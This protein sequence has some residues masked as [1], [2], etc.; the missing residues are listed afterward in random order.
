MRRLS[1]SVLLFSLLTACGPDKVQDAVKQFDLTIIGKGSGTVTSDPVGILCGSRCTASF[2][3]RTN[4]KLTASTGKHVRWEGACSAVGVPSCEVHLDETKAVN[5]TFL[6]PITVNIVGSGAVD[7]APSG[8]ACSNSCPV[9]SPTCAN[10]CEGGVDPLV[11][12][13]LTVTPVNG[14]VFTGWTGRCTGT[15]SCVIPPGEAASV[16]ATFTPASAVTWQ[17]VVNVLGTGQGSVISSPAGISCPN[18]CGM[19]VPN[20][21]TVTL[22][23]SA[24]TG[25]SFAGWSG[26]CTGT[27]L[28]CTVTMNAAK[29]VTARFNTNPVC[30]WARRFGGGF[31]DRASAIAVNPENGNILLSGTIYGAAN[32]GGGA[33]SVP[34]SSSNIFVAAFNSGGSHLYSFGKGAAGSVTVGESASWTADGGIVVAGAFSGSVNLGDG[35]RADN[36][37]TGG[38]FRGFLASYDATGAAGFVRELGATTVMTSGFCAVSVDPVTGRIAVAGE[39]AEPTSFG[40][41]TTLTPTDFDAYVAQYD[42]NGAVRWARKAG[43]AYYDHALA[44][45]TASDGKIVYGGSFYGAADFGN[46]PYPAT[47]ED[48]AFVATYEA[49]GGYVSDK[50]LTAQPDGGFNETRAVAYAANGDLLIA[51][52]ISTETDMGGT[53]LT[54]LGSSDAFVA[55]YLPNGTL[56]WANRLGGTMFDE[57]DAVAVDNAGNVYVAGTWTGTVNFAGT[58]KTAQSFDIFL[59][60]YSATGALQSVRTMGGIGLDQPHAL[61]IDSAGN[62][63]MSGSF[64]NTLNVNGVNL[65]SAGDVDMFFGCFA[66]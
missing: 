7:S 51:G 2:D 65:V 53:T 52:S 50:L 19:Q 39:F 33:L 36:V 32:F 18:G 57:A 59:A 28:S 38:L 58:V 44:V 29:S 55:R 9:A 21:G 37:T 30:G 1:L 25:S 48:S 45:A 60:K 3:E 56:V 13:T 15:G 11:D 61:A 41:P 4:V 63:L 27:A 40:G 8:V 20:N 16:T 26:G 47:Q 62:V 66:P 31:Y 22:T 35:V 46:G 64:E 34:A 54:S 24:V 43:G 42:S 10:S 23:A 6:T 14:F 12:T 17:L 49:D 5:V